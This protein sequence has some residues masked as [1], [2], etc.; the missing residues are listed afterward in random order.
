MG[1]VLFTGEPLNNSGA[2]E[3]GE[4]KVTKLLGNGGDMTD[5]KE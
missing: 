2:E 3:E 1:G 4:I 5:A